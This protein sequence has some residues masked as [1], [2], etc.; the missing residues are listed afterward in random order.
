MLKEEIEKLITEVWA[1]ENK[2]PCA[3]FEKTNLSFDEQTRHDLYLVRVQLG[4][5]INRINTN[6]KIRKDT[7]TL[8]EIS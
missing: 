7:R 8:R 6:D 5:I 2:L 4:I 1:V 3:S